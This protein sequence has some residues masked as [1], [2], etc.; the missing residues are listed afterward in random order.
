MPTASG[1]HVLFQE[2]EMI[3]RKIRTVAVME[4]NHTVSCTAL[5]TAAGRSTR[6]K[7]FKQLMEINGVSM[8]E[9][10]VGLIRE[11]GIRDIVMITGFNENRLREALKEYPIVFLHNEKFATTDMF[12]SAKV[13]L[14]YLQGKAERVLFCPVDVPFFQSE[15][16][17][18]EMKRTENVVYPSFHFHAGHPVLFDGEVIPSLLRY[19]GS[20]GMKGAFD[21]LSGA[22]KYYLDVDDAGILRDLDEPEDLGKD[23]QIR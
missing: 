5:I 15:T 8:A 3:F 6:M 23:P 13:G 11:A 7:Q 21:S 9:R 12:E 19:H 18:L 22:T 16:I 14:R 17:R 1:G 2:A 10:V 20:G 4:K